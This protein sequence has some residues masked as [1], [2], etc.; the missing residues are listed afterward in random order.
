[1]PYF[2]IQEWMHVVEFESVSRSAPDVIPLFPSMRDVS[3]SDESGDDPGP[4]A[5]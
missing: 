4:S 3:G 1:M 5:A 2:T